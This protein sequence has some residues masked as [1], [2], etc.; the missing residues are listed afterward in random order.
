MIWLS[1]ANCLAVQLT[2]TFGSTIAWSA[3]LD[4]KF[5]ESKQIGNQGAK[6]SG[7]TNSSKLEAEQAIVILGGGRRSGAI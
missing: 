2:N 1:S 4:L 6:Q 5:L 3:Q 7:A